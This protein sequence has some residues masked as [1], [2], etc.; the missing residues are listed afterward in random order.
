MTGNMLNGGQVIVDL[1]DPAEGALRLR[2]LRPRQYQLHRRPLRALRR[3]QDDLGPPRERRPASWPTSIT[4]SPASRPRPS[5][6]AGPARPICRS[7]SPTPFSIR[8]RSSPSPATCRRASSTAAPSRNSTGTTRPTSL[9][10]ARLLQA[11]VPADPRRNGAARHPA[12]VENH[13]DRPPRPGRARRAVRYLQGG[14]G[15]RDAGPGGVDRQ[16]LHAAAAPTRR[17]S[18]RPSTCCSRPGAAGRS[19]SARA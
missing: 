3:H 7:A 5:P 10:G 19:S 18:S 8:C 16:H 15:H 1:P 13:G 17:A 12:G 6:P 11:R 4:A 14:R 9:D 2:P